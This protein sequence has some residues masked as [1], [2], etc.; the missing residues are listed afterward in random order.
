MAL[1]PVRELKSGG[2]LGAGY[3]M[4]PLIPVRE[5]KIDPPL[6]PLDEPPPP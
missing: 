4:R 6:H 3:P 2:E 5:L 1:I